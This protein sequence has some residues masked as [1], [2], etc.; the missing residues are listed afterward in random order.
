MNTITSIQIAEVTTRLW[1]P[2]NTNG[3]VEC[4]N[5][6]PNVSLTRRKNVLLTR[7][8]IILQHETL[9][10]QRVSTLNVL[11]NSHHREMMNKGYHYMHIWLVEKLYGYNVFA[12][13]PIFPY[14][15][16][17]NFI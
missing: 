3:K 11:A 5:H 12:K 16:G 13:K 8:K 10:P 6:N 15:K 9:Q 7:R 17:I 14:C 2:N 1:I 4:R